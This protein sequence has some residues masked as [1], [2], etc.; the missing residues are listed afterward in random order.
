[1]LPTILFQ[2]VAIL[3]TSASHGS[4]PP[5]A[6]TSFR[7]GLP[8]EFQERLRVSREQ[9]YER[10]C[11]WDNLTNQ[12]RSQ[13]L[14]S[15]SA[16]AAARRAEALSKLSPEQRLRVERRLEMLDRRTPP[17]ERTTSEPPKYRP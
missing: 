10:R 9:V 12:E 3:A 4:M 2:A 15:L 16:V 17:P 1:M 11:E 5:E 6:D 8:P 13:V 7:E 14:D